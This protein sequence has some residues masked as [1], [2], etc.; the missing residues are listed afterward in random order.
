MAERMKGGAG[1][2]GFLLDDER[3]P[4]VRAVLGYVLSRADAAD[5]AVR[6]VRLAALDFSPAELRAVRRC[7]VLLGSLDAGALAEA[8]IAVGSDPGRSLAMSALRDL[9]TSGRAEIRSAG[10]CRW[11]PDFAVLRGLP[12]DGPVP[13]GAACLS[14]WLGLDA[15]QDSVATVL[16]SIV[17][18]PTA[19]AAAVSRFEALWADA[20]DVLP[21]IVQALVPPDMDDGPRFPPQLAK[22]EAASAEEVSQ[23]RR[24]RGTD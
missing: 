16:T 11:I 19:A 10:T 20:Y 18:G 12:P 5:F 3:T 15:R 21:I 8:A 4:G 9:L 23:D 6:R 7:R 13:G 17:A 2:R 22:T 24:D 1:C 14:G